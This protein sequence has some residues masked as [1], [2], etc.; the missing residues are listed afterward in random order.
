MMRISRRIVVFPWT[1][2][3]IATPHL[4]SIES[5]GCTSNFF[6]TS[7]SALATIH[8]TKR[9]SVIDKRVINVNKRVM[10]TFWRLAELVECLVLEFVSWRSGAKGVKGSSHAFEE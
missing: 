7:E 10:F 9:V 4:R 3:L 6:Q 2:F 1:S 8:T 5:I